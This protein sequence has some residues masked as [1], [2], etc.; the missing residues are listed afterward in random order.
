MSGAGG[1]SKEV[2]SHEWKGGCLKRGAQP[3]VEEGVSQ[4]RCTAMSGGGGSS[5]EVHLRQS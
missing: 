4:K 5:K 1:V 2:H 3:L